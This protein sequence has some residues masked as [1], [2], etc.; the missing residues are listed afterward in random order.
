MG[1]T[2]EL[3]PAAIALDRLTSTH[4]V[5]YQKHDGKHQQQVDPSAYHVERRP[6]HQPTDQKHEKQN[7][8]DDIGEDSHNIYSLSERQRVHRR[9]SMQTAIPAPFSRHT[10]D[11]RAA[12]P[13]RKCKS[14]NNP[15]IA[16][17]AYCNP[18]SSNV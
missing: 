16:V 8:K 11:D 5:D 12:F 2:T 4:Q 13:L 14:A 15:Q 9:R 7:Q 10:P 3:V 17:L 6:G 18:C 1:V